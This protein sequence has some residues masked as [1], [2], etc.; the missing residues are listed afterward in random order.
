MSHAAQLRSSRRL[1]WQ[2]CR[3]SKSSFRAS[4]ALL[5]RPRREAMYALYAFARITD[6]LG[7]SHESV[8]VRSSQLTDW[9]AQLWAHCQCGSSA[10]DSS[11][12]GSTLS[13]TAVSI[14]PAV[15]EC[16]RQYR[17]PVQLLDDIIS[18]VAMDLEPA[19]PRDWSELENY[20]Y[21]VASCVGLACAHIWSDHSCS[22]DIPDR[23]LGTERYTQSAID[24][25]IAFQ[26]TN[27]LRDIA[28]DA[29]RGR[30]YVPHNLF[31]DYQVSAGGWLRAEPCGN[32]AEMLDE[33][34]ER[35]R[36]LYRAGWPTIEILSPHSQRMFSLMWRSYR[37]LLEQVIAD[38]TRLW[39]THRIR[40]PKRQKL[41]LLT[42]HFVSPVYARLSPP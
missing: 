11:H 29:R 35:A 22:A 39:T 25:G 23:V 2:I 28:E 19:Q 15:V 7:D 13:P 8:Q 38:K 3:H 12:P 33:V 32:W 1:C 10:A 42:S 31:V 17:I 18:G 16:V 20:C 30:I 41:G 40:L 24:C 21:H 26:L 27:I 37:S 6:D 4:F 36:R 9:R 34:A 5:D 14:W